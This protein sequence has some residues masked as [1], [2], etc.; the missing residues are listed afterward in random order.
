MLLKKMLE[1]CPPRGIPG[2]PVRTAIDQVLH[3]PDVSDVGGTM[4]HGLAIT[5]SCIDVETLRQQEAVRL[6]IAVFEGLV[7]ECLTSDVDSACIDEPVFRA[8]GAR[9]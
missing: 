3:E 5:S 8:A 7:D 1:G 9:P 6:S 4:Q 2:R